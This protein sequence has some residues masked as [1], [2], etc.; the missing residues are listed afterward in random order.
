MESQTLYGKLLAKYISGKISHEEI[1]LLKTWLEENPAHQELLLELTDAQELQSEINFFDEIDQ[2][3]ALS[4][5]ILKKKQVVADKKIYSFSVKKKYLLSAAVF[6]PLFIIGSI[7]YFTRDA[8]VKSRNVKQV[9]EKENSSTDIPPGGNKAVLTLND[10]TQINLD[11]TKNGTL[12]TEA[13]AKIISQDGKIVYNKTGVTAQK[14]VSYNTVTT[15]RGG[16]YVVVLPDGSKVWLNAQSS[17]RFPTVF[18]TN[19]RI[20]QA[21]GEIYFEVAP[22]KAK[23]FK[24]L[25]KTAYGADSEIEVVGTHFNLNAYSD[26]P[27]NQTTLLKGS[28]NIR[29]GELKKT[30]LPG[31]AGSIRKQSIDI[32]A[33]AP[34]EEIMAWKD[35]FFFF[36]NTDLTSLLQQISRWYDVDVELTGKLTME[37]F[38]GKIPRNMSLSTLLKI[39]ELYNEIQ[40]NKKGGKIIIKA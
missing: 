23:P 19:E 25:F 14:H 35:G 34:V 37:G 5:V 4:S 21:S 1:L 16:Q 20:V 2:H 24:V 13:G 17:L 38:S 10:G 8:W 29:S 6:V 3:A 32:D 30:L 9:V 39:L 7:L 40:I 15:P 26:N 28:V 12:A 22:N 27:A 33:H 31:Q 11:S 36:N 18:T